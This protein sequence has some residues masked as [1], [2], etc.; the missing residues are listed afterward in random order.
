MLVDDVA[1]G[2]LGRTALRIEDRLDSGWATPRVRATLATLLVHAGRA[3]PIDA[4]LAWAWPEGAATPRNPMATFHTYATR[5]RRAL[6]RVSSP[7]TLY[8]ENGFYRLDV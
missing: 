1:F 4:L 3:V 5:I 6:E 8:A 7:A 2:I